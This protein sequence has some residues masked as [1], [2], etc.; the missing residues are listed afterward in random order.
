MKGPSISSD[1]RDDRGAATVFLVGFAVVLLV[2]AGLVVDGGLAIN[3]RQRVADDVEQAARAGSAHLDE[4]E[5]R[6]DGLVRIDPVAARAATTRFLRAR[7][8]PAGGIRVQATPNQ[9]TVAATLQQKTA[10]LSLIFVDDFTIT[11]T[12]TARPA[13]GII[14]EVAP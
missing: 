6:A 12:G 13:V 14:Q 11:A 5:L 3:A 1:D 7:G 10:L 2:L 4:D 8:Y 9:V